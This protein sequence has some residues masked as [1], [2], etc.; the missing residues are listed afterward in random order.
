MYLWV[1]VYMCVSVGLHECLY[2]YM[3]VLSDYVL[4]GCIDLCFSAFW[5]SVHDC[6]YLCVFV[7]ILCVCVLCISACTF[8][9][10]CVNVLIFYIY[11]HFIY[12]CVHVCFCT[13]LFI[14]AHTYRKGLN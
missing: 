12:V 2:A 1:N 8:C 13:S 3:H 9:V 5:V 10:L 7:T 4:L 6:V 14:H 11:G